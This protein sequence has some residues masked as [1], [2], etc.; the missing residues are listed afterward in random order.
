[1]K[2]LASAALEAAFFI[3]VLPAQDIANAQ[4][5]VHA[6]AIVSVAPNAWGVGTP[7]PT[8]REAMFTGAIGERV[9]VIGGSNDSAVLSV[10]EIYDTPSDS[11]TTG[12]PM[13]TA[14]T[15]GAAAVVNN[16]LYAIGGQNTGGPLAVV[17]A[18]DPSTDTWTTKSPMPAP[19]DSLSAIAAN[20]LIYV[21][22]GYTPS[23]GR[24]AT[25]LAYNP[26]TNTWTTEASLK[27]AKTQSALGAFG[28]TIVSAGGLLASS[29]ATTDTESYSIAGNAWTAVAPLPS[30]RHAACYESA[31]NMLFVAGGHSTG[32]GSPQSMLFAYDNDTNTW[33]SGLPAMPYPSVNMGSA[34]IGG[35][36]YCFGGSNDGDPLAGTIYNYVQ[37][38]QPDIPPSISAGGVVSASAFGEFTSVSPGSW[39]EIYGLNLSPDTRGW[40]LADFTGTEAPLSLDGLTV[41]VGGAQAFID[42][43]SPGQVNALLSSTTPTGSQQLIVTTAEGSSA[44]YT[45]TVNPTEPGLLAP[46]NFVVGG[47]QY[48]VAIFTDGAYALP[49]GAVAGVNSRPAQ[50]GDVLTLYGVGFGSVTPSTPAGQLAEQLTTLTLPLQVSIGGVPATVLYNGLAP[51]FTGLYQFNIQVPAAP[52]GN[53]VPLT[54]SLNGV[55]GTQA[56]AIAIGQ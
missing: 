51:D 12:S 14:R 30:A 40:T 4:S 3:S 47:T 10:N 38:Y 37:I 43:I 44:A 25:V 42:Y 45:L 52:S 24:Q 46:Y 16:V 56:L 55:S 17:E 22:G 35:R 49:T 39:I 13:P 36:L 29:N 15:L 23:T 26:A 41:T 53:A 34:S 19:L 6:N 54:F 27:T 33:T 18:Y 1:M 8:A 28:N 5:S 7:M 11:W 50:P 2:R 32:S 21:V 31:G 9:Y 20:N 48:A